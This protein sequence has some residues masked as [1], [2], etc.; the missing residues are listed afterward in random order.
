MI[1]MED[2]EPRN[3]YL[4]IWWF[5]FLTKAARQAVIGERNDAGIT[6][7]WYGKNELW[8]LPHMVYKN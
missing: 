7:H 2:G 1:G 3:R 5:D 8:P 6:G 4:L